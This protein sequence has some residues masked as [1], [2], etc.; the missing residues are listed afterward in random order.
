MNLDDEIQEHYKQLIDSNSPDAVYNLF[1]E[2]M[3]LPNEE[4]RDYILKMHETHEYVGKITNFVE[5]YRDFT[6]LFHNGFCDS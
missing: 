3:V 5:L 4:N 1:K 2:T 6:I